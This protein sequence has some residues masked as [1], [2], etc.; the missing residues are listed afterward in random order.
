[1][2]NGLMHRGALPLATVVERPT[3]Q[4]DRRVEKEKGK[5]A[6][7]CCRVQCVLSSKALQFCYCR[8]YKYIFCWDLILHMRVS[9]F[10]IVKSKLGETSLGCQLNG[11]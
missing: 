7:R 11:K 2:K 3:G 5:M 10:V 8:V 1:M 9:S 6:R 4:R